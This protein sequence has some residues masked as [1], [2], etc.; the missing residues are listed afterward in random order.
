[1]KMVICWDVKPYSLVEI[2]QYFGGAYCLMTLI[3][4]EMSVS[5]MSINFYQATCRNSP[6]DKSC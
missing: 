2:G 6:Q 5:E 1:M 3:M 4:G